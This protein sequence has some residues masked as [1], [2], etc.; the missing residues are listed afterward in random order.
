MAARL[1][2]VASSCQWQRTCLGVGPSGGARNQ[3]E[4]SKH[5]QQVL[6]PHTSWSKPFASLWKPCRSEA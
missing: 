6:R 2:Q 5:A 4:V 1:T 3:H